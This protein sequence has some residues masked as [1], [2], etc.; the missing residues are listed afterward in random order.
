M[1]FDFVWDGAE[2]KVL[3]MSSAWR[4]DWYED[5]PL[6]YHDLQP[7]GKRGSEYFSEIGRILRG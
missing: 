5:C 7:T 6:Y 3:E 1:C 2:M 4:A